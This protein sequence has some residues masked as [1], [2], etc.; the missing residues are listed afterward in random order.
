VHPCPGG[1]FGMPL[2]EH[3][4]LLEGGAPL[5][6]EW[7]NQRDEIHKERKD[8][9]TEE[10]PRTLMPICRDTSPVTLE[11]QVPPTHWCTTCWRAVPERAYA[12]EEQPGD[13]PALFLW[14]HIRLPPMGLP[15]VS[16]LFL[17]GPAQQKAAWRHA[18]T[19]LGMPALFHQKHG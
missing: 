17:R 13:T 18:C 12:I 6:E 4:C 7:C 19:F 8:C 11:T 16:M 1:P 9:A 15:P 2:Q 14:K 3:S 10:T 5:L